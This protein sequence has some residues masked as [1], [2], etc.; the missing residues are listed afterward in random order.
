MERHA[1]RTVAKYGKYA[2]A[3]SAAVAAI[4]FEG[5]SA[6]IRPGDQPAGDT[7]R[8]TYGSSS[9]TPGSEVDPVNVVFWG[10]YGGIGPWS[11]D[12]VLSETAAVAGF[13]WDGGST[14]YFWDHG[15]CEPMEEQN[16]TGGRIE[17]RYHMRYD[18]GDLG[19]VPAW[20]PLLPGYYATSDAHHEDWILL[21]NESGWPPGNH[22]VDSNLDEPPGGFVMARDYVVGRFADAGYE[23]FYE[24]DWHNGDRW[25]VQCDGWPAWSDG[26]VAFVKVPRDGG[27]G[28][29]FAGGDIC[30]RG[31]C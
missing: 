24:Y 22:A 30:N 4:V 1:L 10:F 16:A 18:Q 12:T 7:G 6:H 11:V 25:F 5:A 3:T 9:C 13:W 26:I 28:V 23:F 14:Q 2:A 31:F 20:D 17:T 29:P 19:G 15:Q 21:C 27:G 8:F